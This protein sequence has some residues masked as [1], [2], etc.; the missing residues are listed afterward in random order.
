MLA[1]DC[2][3]D[4]PFGPVSN[5][6]RIVALFSDEQFETGVY[7]RDYPSKIPDLI[8]KIH[9]RHIQLYMAM[10]D[11][12]MVQQLAEA[13]GSE[14]ELIPGGDGLASIDFSLL[15]GQLGK[16]ISAS[17]IQATGESQ[18]TRALFGQNR[19]VETRHRFI[20]TKNIY[21]TRQ[22]NLY[23]WYYACTGG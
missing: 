12:P 23:L 18:Y 7:D 22:P 19:F 21:K 6:K 1:L 9:A 11:G 20:F 4:Y 3:L 8:N 10:P 16:S 14:V 15:L 13:N 2:A 17:K 5:T